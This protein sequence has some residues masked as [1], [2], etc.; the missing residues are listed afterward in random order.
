MRRRGFS[1]IELSV[2]MFISMLILSAIY[3]VFLASRSGYQSAKTSFQLSEEAEIAFRTLQRDL[4]ET[5]LGSIRSA[6]GGASMV[7]ARN[8]EDPGPFPI[9]AAGVP[10]WQSYVFYTLVPVDDQVGTLVRWT[11]PGPAGQ[12][13][14]L[15]ATT[16]PFPILD[17]RHRSEV[18]HSLLLPG[19]TV[20]IRNGLAAVVEDAQAPGGFSLGFL[21]TDDSV[22]PVNPAERTDEQHDGWSRG[23]TRMVRVDLQVLSASSETGKIGYTHFDLVV[24]PRN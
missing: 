9:T 16:P 21:R 19:K 8:P 4:R 18:L 7:S 17:G 5:S 11:A 2:Y 22:S 1:L 24:T 3:M 6:R 14:P 10:Q 15:A 23:N 13:L 12:V 20:E